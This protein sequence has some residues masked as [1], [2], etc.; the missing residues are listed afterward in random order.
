MTTNL[1]CVTAPVYSWEDHERVP[2]PSPPTIERDQQKLIH[3]VGISGGASKS[4]GWVEER[5]LVASG[6]QRGRRFVGLHDGGGEG[7]AGG[8]QRRRRVPVVET[9][10]RAHNM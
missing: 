5:V 9:V 7:R 6:W 4:H 2:T 1:L 8:G 3:E 10:D